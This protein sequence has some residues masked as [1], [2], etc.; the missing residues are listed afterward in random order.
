MNFIWETN[1]NVDPVA[2]KEDYGN[3]A[4][5]GQPPPR[6]G[7][8]GLDRPRGGGRHLRGVRGQRPLQRRQRE[9]LR[10]EQLM[11]NQDGEFPL[12]KVSASEQNLKEFTGI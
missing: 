6:G 11:L 7:A 3:C 2:T 1:H 12:Q 10:C 5:C 4:V 9:A 8:P